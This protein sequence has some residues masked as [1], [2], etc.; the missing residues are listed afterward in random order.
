MTNGNDS[1]DHK[2]KTDFCL[3]RDFFDAF[4]ALDI[5]YL[6]IRNIRMGLSY[7][8]EGTKAKELYVVSVEENIS[9]NYD[10]EK[11]LPQNIDNKRHHHLYPGSMNKKPKHDSTF[12]EL[13][14]KQFT[15]GID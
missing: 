13:F 4:P 7:S 14:M 3:H 15:E 10:C 2:L 5:Y 6:I 12:K 9:S 11:N 1:D 8:I